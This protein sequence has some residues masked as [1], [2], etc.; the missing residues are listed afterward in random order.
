MV[1]HDRGQAVAGR[2]GVVEVALGVGLEPHREFVEMLGDLVVVVEVFIKVDLAVAVEVAEADDL[3]AAADVDPARDDLEPQRLEQ[4]R[5]DPPPG[6]ALAPAY[7][8]RRPATHRRP[9]C[10]PPH[11]GRRA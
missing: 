8:S 5:G 4:T 3:V 6:E 1:R 11:D 7:R 2:L 9:R 10:R